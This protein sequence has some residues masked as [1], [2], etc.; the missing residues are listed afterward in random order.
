MKKFA[1]VFCLFLAFT[2][3]EASAA[4]Q[5]ELGTYGEWTAYTFEENG[6][7][8]C[9]MS[10]KPNKST[11]KYSKRGEVAVMITHRTAEGTKDVFSFMA[12]YAYKN[13][14][15]VDV[16]IDGKSFALFTQ[17]DMAW[18]ADAA[19]DLALSKALKKGS[20]MVIKGVS[21]RGTETKDE[22]NLNGATK[23]YEAISKA[24]G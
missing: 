16:A 5:V 19:A 22:F 21:A 10:A 1:F 4:E 7:K 6:G 3:F 14:S 12:G 20:K 11:G 8:V 24:C 18:A 23:A 2:S 13:A 17:N 15:Q 9:Y